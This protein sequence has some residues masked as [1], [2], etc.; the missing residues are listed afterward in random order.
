MHWQKYA[1]DAMTTLFYT[2]SEDRAETANAIVTLFTRS[3]A[4]R[5]DPGDLV[6]HHRMGGWRTMLAGGSTPTETDGA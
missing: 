1:Q 5:W 3:Q 6:L 2:K 4:S